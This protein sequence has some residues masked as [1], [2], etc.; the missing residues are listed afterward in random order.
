M[1][2]FFDSEIVRESINELDRLQEKLFS[3]MFYVPFFDNES[4]REHLNTMREFLE[5]Q[6]LL[7]FRISLSDDSQAVEM[8][9]KII[10]SAKM[11]G[12]EDNQ[13]INAFFDQMEKSIKNL[14]ETLDT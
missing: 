3:E 6:K 10:E 4:K 11:F 5:K 1:S 13:S 12:L 9:E 8:K 2:G 7:V 14:E